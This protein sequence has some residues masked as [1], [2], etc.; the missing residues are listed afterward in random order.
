MKRL[1]QLTILGVFIACYNGNAQSSLSQTI[2]GY[3]I[4]ADSKKP[5]IGATV[6]LIT[7]SKAVITDST[8]EFQ[9]QNVP[10]G[11]QSLIISMMGYDAKTVAEINVTSGKEVSL[12]I[13]LTENIKELSEVRISSR[14]S[15]SK[16][17]NEFATASARS[18]SVE[19]TKRYAA[20]AYDP[21]R[22][23]MNFAG[24]GNNGDGN[25][26]IV[27]RGNSPKGVLWRLEGIEIPNPNHFGSLGNSGGAISMLSSSTLGT[28]D[29][30]TGAFPAEF[31]AATSGVFDLNFRQGNKDKKEYA[32]MIGGLG[33][34]AAAEGPFRKGGEASYLINYRYSTLSLLKG[35]LDNLA[36]IL[37]EYQDLSFKVNMPT[38]R[39]GT[40]SVFGLGGMNTVTKDPPKDSTKWTDDDPNFVLDGKGKTGIVGVSHQYFFNENSFLKSIISAS[41]TVYREKVDSLDPKNDY[42]VEQIGRTSTT[43]LAYRISLMYNNK[44]NARH[45]IRAGIIGSQLQYDY[46]SR[47]YDEADK[48]W[49]QTLSGNGNTNF[50]QSYVQWK[51]RIV[52]QLTVN[53]GLHTSLF[54]LNST[55]TVE[56]RLAVTYQPN[57]NHTIVAAAGLHSRPEHLSTYL[58]EPDYNNTGKSQPN[59]DLE[60]PKALHY[61]LSYEVGLQ[62][63]WRVKT[64][65]YYQKLYDVPVE[66]KSGSYF[67]MLNAASIFDLRDLHQL[68]STGKGKNYGVDVTVE[69]PFNR[70]YYVLFTGSIFQSKYTNYSGD[71]F[72]TRFNREYQGNIVAGKEWKTGRENK[73]VIGLNGKIL[74]SGGLKESPIDL[75]AS[76][77]RGKVQFVPGKFYSETG[78]M[79][80]R[81]DVGFSYKVNKRAATHTISFDVQNL[82]NHQNLYFSWYD[83]D[84]GQIKKVYQM[85]FFPIINYRIE[86]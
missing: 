23:A 64:E 46:D 9:I 70:N 71:E 81:F 18:F 6:S 55:S 56:P 74:A 44:I 3:V 54:S 67:S 28:S 16:S 14:R 21:A 37:P 49:R 35:F 82:T 17:T 45:T 69:K 33:V 11:R 31:G 5:L 41:A 59:K 25:N 77:L 26:E 76:R 36:G 86:F 62:K 10:L 29:F 50:Y 19:E 52:K 78:D 73:N 79:Y 72:N 7:S 42:A 68:V 2:K 48:I 47:Y 61:I 75:E 66:E 20:A 1:I 22:M 8:G 34:E 12:T 65:A 51:Y 83:N 40:F 30:Y 27:V 13:S 80:Y 63:G 24:V 60:I 84:K 4:D 32:L 43:D 57:N 39:A 15:R 58:I 38:K 53:A 85:G